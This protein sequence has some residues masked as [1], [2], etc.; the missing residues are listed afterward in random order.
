[1][2][3]YSYLRHLL[4]DERALW[5]YSMEGRC[6]SVDDV[7]RH[8]MLK[9]RGLSVQIPDHYYRLGLE[10]SFDG[11]K[12]LSQLFTVGLG[13]I[14]RRYLEIRHGKIYVVAN[15]QNEW[16]LMLPSMPPLLLIA[17]RLW[18]EFPLER[19]EE[20]DYVKKYI[21]PNV[22]YTALVSPYLPRLEEMMVGGGL[23]DIH[24]HLNGALETD[25]TWQDFLSKPFEI[26]DELEKAFEKGKVKEQY[27]EVSSLLN[28][29]KFYQLLR[30]AALLR[31]L[32]FRYVN[33]I[34]MDNM[35]LM[36][37]NP[38]LET[39]LK[40]V[41]EADGEETD[42][43]HPLAGI[44]GDDI[45]SHV[46][47][48]LLYI[49]VFQ[50]LSLHPDNDTVS[51]V[52]HYYLLILG[53]VNRMLVQQTVHYGFEEFQKFT[54]NGLREYS[55][56][57]Y[58]RRFLQ[59]A[60][61]KLRYINLLEGRF[62]PKDSKTM[63]ED[64]LDLIRTGWKELTQ[65]QSA[66][67]IKEARL[68]MVAHFIKQPDNH[69]DGLIRHKALRLRVEH[70]AEVL[71]E[72]F[73]EQTFYN[74]AITGIDAAASEFD[75]PPEV[76]APVY[77]KLR[78]AGFEHFTYHA[79]E[80]F[81]HILSGLRAI[82]EAITFLDLRRCDR[83]GHATAAGVPVGL[84]RKNVGERIFIRQGE[85]LDNLLFAY[86]MI[87]QY[88]DTEMH[89]LLPLIA[90]RIDKLNYAIYQEY[91]PLT[92][93]IDS[94]QERYRNPQKI[95]DG[96]ET[97]GFNPSEKEK[98]FLSYH[99]KTVAERYNAI[100]EIDSLELFNEQHLT[101]LQ[102]IVLGIM[103][104]REIVIETLPTS[105]VIIGNHHSFSTYHLITWYEWKR[106]GL[107]IPPIVVGTDD[108]G[109]FA[110]NI[111]NEYCNIYCQMM[112]DKRMNAE[113][114]MA[115]IRELDANARLYAFK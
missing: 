65:K 81:F 50:Y 57:H 55:E 113:D 88:G 12:E 4:N 115:F 92:L 105:N 114:I 89:S 7:K 18:Q 32:L 63:N 58:S 22:S 13:R 5:S 80:D 108:V 46:L 60:G 37:G 86:C 93:Q 99:S 3:T 40:R 87:N 69:P 45:P 54:M 16:Q 38:T 62:S 27:L 56:K 33:G 44:V 67:G 71:T 75:A 70:R 59:M 112:Y 48:A 95:L 76:F 19:G 15:L 64:M 1:M 109:I 39:L 6:L 47:E 73:K 10:R 23:S 42:K 14:A 2:N 41:K 29:A 110:T 24:L 101:K 85:W 25:I 11:I 96:Y 9:E 84:W 74:E 111:Y 82:Y 49:E 77:R 51:S 94:W 26:R 103:H 83:I 72:M 43:R 90:L 17:M 35:S 107:P 106:Q 52:F 30:T 36:D 91:L 97:D 100:I 28:P 8:V 102:Q 31:E 66:L 61:N 79:G 98:L 20:K 78:S 53:L 68:Y 21:I 104:D 34:S